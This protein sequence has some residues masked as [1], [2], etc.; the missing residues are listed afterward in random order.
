MDDLELLRELVASEHFE[1]M[2]GQWTTEGLVCVA[3]GDAHGGPAFVSP[4]AAAGKCHTAWLRDGVLNMHDSDIPKHVPIPDLSD[5]ATRGCLLEM[6]RRA[7][8]DPNMSIWRDPKAVQEVASV[9][10]SD[11]GHRVTK[12]LHRAGW[13]EWAVWRWLPEPGWDGVAPDDGPTYP[14]HG[15]ECVGSGATESEALVAALLAAPGKGE[16]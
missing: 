16:K 6:V 7:W 14:G 2:P 9:E 3:S 15:G 11:D 13:S 8:G 4:W 12:Y 5:A 10:T 1:W